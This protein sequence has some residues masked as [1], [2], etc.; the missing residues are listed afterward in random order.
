MFDREQNK[1]H[2][3]AANDFF[4]YF[5]LKKR[6]AIFHKAFRGSSNFAS[7]VFKSNIVYVIRSYTLLIIHDF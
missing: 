7:Y 4:F 1:R 2:N 3:D 5:L 6:G